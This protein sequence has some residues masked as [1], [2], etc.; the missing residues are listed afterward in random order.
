MIKFEVGKKYTHGWIGDSNLFTTWEVIART[1]KTITI[2]NG[3]EIHKRRIIKYY[4]DRD[5]IEAIYPLGEFSMCPT[6]RA[7]N[8][9]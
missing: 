8:N 7:A 2:K 9:Y 3:D 4:A 6:L 5:G 1:E